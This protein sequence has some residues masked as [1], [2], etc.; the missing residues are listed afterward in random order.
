MTGNTDQTLESC[1]GGRASTAMDEATEHAVGFLDEFKLLHTP[2]QPPPLAAMVEEDAT[3][4]DDTKTRI[5]SK[6]HRE[7]FSEAE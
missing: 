7:Q 4:E 6:A 1:L 3:D 2:D 5:I